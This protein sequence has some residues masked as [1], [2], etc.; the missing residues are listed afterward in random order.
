MS[1]GNI[2]KRDWPIGHSG[3]VGVLNVGIVGVLNIGIVIMIGRGLD[4]LV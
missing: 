3:S 4:N 1:G 2:I